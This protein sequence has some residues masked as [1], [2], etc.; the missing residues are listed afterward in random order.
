M[1]EMELQ[2]SVSTELSGT[3]CCTLIDRRSSIPLD[4]ARITC[5]WRD[6][7]VTQHDADRSGR[8]STR[9]PQGVYDLVVSARGYLSLLIRGVGVLGGHQQVV[10]RALIPGEGNTPEGEPATALGG[11]ITN[12]FGRSV[13]SLTVRLTAERGDTAFTTRTDRDGAFLFHGVVPQMYDLDI[14][15]SERR[16]AR[17]HIPIG[18]ARD[19]VRYDLRIMQA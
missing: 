18:G 5:V 3:L 17:E 12:R 8:F 1:N 4:C 16:L 19:F 10:T 14:S 13:S 7:R 11:Y 6:N 2:A 9:M 15:S